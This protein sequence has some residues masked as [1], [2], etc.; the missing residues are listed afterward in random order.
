LNEG[1]CPRQSDFRVRDA[2]DEEPASC[3]CQERWGEL[4]FFDG[5]IATAI[6]REAIVVI[7]T[8]WGIR[9]DDAAWEAPPGGP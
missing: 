5:K 6:S 4:T 1:C 9:A 8:P 7:T 2:F 3:E